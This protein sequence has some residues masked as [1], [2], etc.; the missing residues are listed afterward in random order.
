MNKNIGVVISI[1]VAIVVVL[2]AVLLYF[3]G[4]LKLSASSG[5]SGGSSNGV[6][7]IS[8]HDTSSGPVTAS[9]YI[10]F[11]VVMVHKADTS[12]SGWYNL[13]VN[14]SAV[15]ISSLT[16]ISMAKVVG[17]GTL[18]D[19]HY[20]NVW[21]GVKNAY[22]MAGGNNISLTIPSNQTYMKM[23]GSFFINGTAK[24]SVDVDISINMNYMIESHM[25]SVFGHIDQT[26][27][28]GY[29]SSY[30]YT[31]ITVHDAENM[32]MNMSGSVYITLNFS[33]I[34][35]VSTTGAKIIEKNVNMDINI[36]K[37]LNKTDVAV[38]WNGSIP[39]GNYTDMIFQ[40]SNVSVNMHMHMFLKYYN[41]SGY[42]NVGNGI[43]IT[44]PCN[45]SMLSASNMRVDVD[46]SYN[47]TALIFNRNMVMSGTV[48]GTYS[49]SSMA[50]AAGTPKR[51]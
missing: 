5:S 25:L 32:P 26:N 17:T 1:V 33:S 39:S 34:T 4:I 31:S 15:E 36:T 12:S 10:S 38:V 14:R 44:V 45:L 49:M 35:F 28:A 27:S 41:F 42:I 48:D 7:D 24:S 46:V 2:A 18:S 37:Y 3:P 47:L 19:G 23:V 50:F 13:T 9:M 11:S 8:V 16:S 51:V 40:I 22:I 43:N 21:I 6:L 29:V 20:T 30:S